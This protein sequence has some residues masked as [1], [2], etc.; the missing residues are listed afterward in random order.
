[1]ENKKGCKVFFHPN[2][3]IWPDGTT[4]PKPA[5]FEDGIMYEKQGFVWPKGT[6]SLSRA[7]YRKHTS[8]NY[9]N[10]IRFYTANGKGEGFDPQNI[11][12][13]FGY[14][15]WPCDS[16]ERTN[17]GHDSNYFDPEWAMGGDSVYLYMCWDPIITYDMGDEIILDFVYKT[18]GDE[19]TVLGEG[20]KTNFSLNRMDYN[21]DGYTGA[22][23]IPVREKKLSHWE[24][25][26]GQ[27]Y[28]IGSVHTF[29]EPITLYAK[30]ER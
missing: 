18:D 11:C 23:E 6:D 5:P 25:E 3:G 8:Q 20:G 22:V 27:K 4:E 29:L 17:H 26:K 28:E 1:M 19:Y 16:W 7:G 10:I 9:L 14:D 30:Y 2:G 12:N 21:V 13:G 15:C 24:D